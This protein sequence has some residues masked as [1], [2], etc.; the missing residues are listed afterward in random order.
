MKHVIKVIRIL[1]HVH[2]DI[3]KLDINHVYGME[4]NILNILD[5]KKMKN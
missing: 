5:L 4:K 1:E 2:V 3:Q